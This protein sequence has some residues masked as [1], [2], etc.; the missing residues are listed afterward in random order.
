MK[1]IATYP[2]QNDN[3]L[4]IYE[5]CQITGNPKVIVFVGLN[6]EE[7]K[8]YSFGVDIDDSCGFWWNKDTFIPFSD[9]IKLEQ[10][11]TNFKINMCKPAI[12][13]E[14]LSYTMQKAINTFF[15]QGE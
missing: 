5:I 3:Y 13:A 2:L 8:P 9:C 4:K 6:E 14:E 12:P 10:N 7:P 11:E 15:M 1:A